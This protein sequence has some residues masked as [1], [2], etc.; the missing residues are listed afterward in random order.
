MLHA[1][2]IHAD[3]SV[4]YKNR[5]VRTAAHML[6]EE[7]RSNIYRSLIPIDWRAI[8]AALQNH[9]R[10]G[11]LFANVANT[12]IVSFNGKLLALVESSIPY[13]L[14]SSPC[15][16][17]VG[18][19]DFEGKW[20]FPFTAHPKIDPAT[21]EMF[22]FGY[23]VV[24]RPPYVKYGVV[25]PQGELVHQ[26]SIDSIKRP[27]MMHDFAI[28][29]NHTI[30]MH[31]PLLFEW[32]GLF[33]GHPVLR[34]DKQQPAR[35]GILKRKDPGSEVRWIESSPC[36]VFHTVNAW[37]EGND[38]VLL[39]CRYDDVD[40]IDV[41]KNQPYLY[42]WRFNASNGVMT[43][44]VLDQ[45]RWLEFPSINPQYVGRKNR[46]SYLNNSLSGFV[47][48]DYETSSFKE[49]NFGD[50]RV[51]GEPQFVPRPSGMG[52][53]DGWVLGFTTD[54]MGDQSEFIVLNAQDLSLIA[55]VH[56]PAR[57]PLGFHGSFFQP[58]TDCCV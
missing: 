19:F 12:S 15:L 31:L 26:T 11:S 37:E 3:G 28:T 6:S 58:S 44:K 25:S 27:C 42:E 16:S 29:E 53:D 20:Q 56:I 30:F 45:S 17:T 18:P 43:E 2:V 41:R 54:V 13:E 22:V 55:H 10:T 46:Y 35:F 32:G 21:G 8:G 23:S 52:E 39:G 24:G 4:S 5:Y 57:V 40:V 1:V 49:Y 47:K 50:N 33:G 9:W 51:G 34:F 14:S 7:R 36:Y 48:Y 38:I